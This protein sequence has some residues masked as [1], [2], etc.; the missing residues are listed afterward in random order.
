M[1]SEGI[2]LMKMADIVFVEHKP[3]CY[4]DFLSFEY[5]DQ[6]YKFEHGTIRNIFSQLQKKGDIEKEYKCGPTFYTARHQ[7]WK[8]ND[9]EPYGEWHSY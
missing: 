9:S 8:I 3:F 5:E 1:V 4:R 6:Q 7:I 2:I